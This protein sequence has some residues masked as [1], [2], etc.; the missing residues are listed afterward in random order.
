MRRILIIGILLGILLI[1][2]GC[3]GITGFLTFKEP[4]KHC[5]PN[6]TIASFNIRKLSD[7]SRNDNEL[8]KIASVLKQFDLIAVQEI[9]GDKII[10]NRITKKLAEKGKKYDF[11]ISKPVGNKQKEKYAFIFNNKI[12]LVSKPKIYY[13][14]FDKFIR[15]PYI[16]SFKADEFDFDIFTIH[17]LYGDSAYDRAPEMRQIANVYEYYQEKDS[18]END[19]ILLGDFNTQPWQDNFDYIKE[20]PDIKIAIPKGKST[21]GKYG[22]LYDNIIFDSNSAEYTGVHGIYYF[23]SILGLE[24]KE[25]KKAVSDHRPVYAVFCTGEDDD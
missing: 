7:A 12:N 8:D 25:A 10:L 24:Q 5:S 17:I 21:I 20:I 11:I 14:K 6:I 2:T 3:K 16:A 18:D 13:D 19:L 23:D 22:H 1:L 9:T 4:I 15:E